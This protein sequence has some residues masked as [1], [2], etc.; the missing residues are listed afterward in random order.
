MPPDDSDSAASGFGAVCGG[1]VGPAGADDAPIGWGPRAE[2]TCAATALSTTTSKL[3]AVMDGIIAYLSWRRRSTSPITPKSTQITAPISTVAPR[4]I[5]K[6][7]PPDIME[8]NS[9]MNTPK[10]DRKRRRVGKEGRARQAEE[11]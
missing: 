5:T 6:S 2:V 9:P 11:R 10:K 4:V 1:G 3:T 7:W 8:I